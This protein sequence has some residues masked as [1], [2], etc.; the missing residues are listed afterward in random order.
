MSLMLAG[1]GNS[2]AAGYR[3]E[4]TASGIRAEMAARA[5]AL[6]VRETS[7]SGYN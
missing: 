1:S 5:A 6:R 3:Q 7:M 4:L 2:S